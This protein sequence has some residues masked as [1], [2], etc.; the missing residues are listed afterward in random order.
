MDS[1]FK[2]I[3]ANTQAIQILIYPANPE[4][5]KCVDRLIAAKIQSRLCHTGLSVW[6]PVESEFMSG[7]RRYVWRSFVVNSC[8]SGSLQP[9][10]ALLLERACKQSLDIHKICQQYNLTERER[11]ALEFLIQGL[12]AQEIAARMQISRNTVKAFLRLVMIK[13]GVSSRIGVIRKVVQFGGITLVSNALS[14]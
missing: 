5:I 9:H 6:L 11:Q 7:R 14:D 8:T 3:Y 12:N 2:P 4:R 10:V 13:M 1:R